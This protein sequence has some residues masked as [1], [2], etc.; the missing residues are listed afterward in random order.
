MNYKSRFSVGLSHALS[1]LFL[2][3]SL[4]LLIGCGGG[5][6]V[7]ADQDELSRYIQEHPEL[8][9]ASAEENKTASGEAPP[10]K[11]AVKPSDS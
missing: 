10:T 9:D 2:A 1:V 3:G 8:E 7:V 5:V 11:Q 4:S 6:D